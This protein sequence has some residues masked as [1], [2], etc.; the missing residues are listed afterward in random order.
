MGQDI[1]PDI[2]QL[3]I[4]EKI[5]R[6][7]KGQELH[8]YTVELQKGQVLKI[9]FVEKGTDVIAV[10][11]RDADQ[12][13]VS[14][15]YNAGNGFMRESLI[16][17]AEEN[18]VHDIIVRAQQMTEE[19]VEAKY[20]ITA[21]LRDF[22]NSTDTQRIQAEKLIEEAN[23]IIVNKDTENLPQ[24][25]SKL[26]ESIK[27][28]RLIG[29][30][31]WEAIAAMFL[32]SAYAGMQNFTQ[33]ETAYLK[34]LSLFDRINNKGELESVYFSLAA[35]YASSKNEAKA[36]L[37]I[38]QGTEIAR[39]L[40]DKRFE[41]FNSTL[42]NADLADLKE[43]SA[44]ITF[45]DIEKE[46]ATARVK[47]DKLAE[48]SVW[49]KKLYQLVIE[50][51]DSDDASN[52]H[53]LLNK[54]EREGLSLARE[55]KDRNA[56]MRI[57]INLGLGYQNIT[58]DDDENQIK[59][60]V[61]NEKSKKFL[62]QSL[63]I[64]RNTKDV[65]FEAVIEAVFYSL[66]ETDN[67]K[68]S[69]FFGKKSI[70][71]TQ[72]F[73]R[74]A[75]AADKE[76]QQEL[77]KQTEGI[78]EEFAT[79]LIS[80]EHR[81][82]EAL[83]VINLGRDQEFFDF[84]LI[85]NQKPFNLTFT[86]REA[87]NLRLFD[88]TLDKVAAKYSAP[89]ANYQTAA[90]E[91]RP[92][93]NQL[94]RNFDAEDSDKDL[95]QNV[96]DL[97]DMQNVLSELS[98][99]TG[100]N[101]AAIYVTSEAD[102]ILLITASQIKAFAKKD[103]IS[104]NADETSLLYQEIISQVKAGNISK[105]EAE[106]KIAEVPSLSKRKFDELLKEKP[107][108]KPLE[109]L[110]TLTSPQYDPRPA[111]STL[112]KRIFK[113]SEIKQDGNPG[114]TLENELAVTNTEVLLWSLRGALRYV[115]MAALY[116]EDNK[117]YLVEKFENVMFTRARKERFLAEP[118]IWT[119]GEGFGTSI[120]YTVGDLNFP[121]L[122]DVPQE[123]STILGDAA[124]NQKG[125]YNGQIFLNKSFTRQSLLN[126]PQNKPSFVHIASH[127]RFKAGDARNS[128]LLLGDGNTFSILDM[129]LDNNLFAGVDL[130]TLSACETAA[131]QEDANGKEIDGFAELAQRLGASSVIATLWQVNDKGTSAL[132]TEFYRLRKENPTASKSQIL[133]MAQLSLLYGKN[134]A[135]LSK[136]NGSVRG[137]GNSGKNKIPQSENTEKLIPFKASG[138]SDFEHPYFW[139]P[140]VLFGNSN[141]EKVSNPYIAA[142]PA[143]NNYSNSNSNS[144]GAFSMSNL[145]GLWEGVFD[146]QQYYC[147][148]EIQSIEG[149]T[150]RGLLH[151]QGAT[152]EVSGFIDPAS[153]Q[154]SFIETK[155]V[156]LGNNKDWLLGSNRGTFSV[157]GNNIS[158]DGF[159]GSVSY[160]WSFR[161]SGTGGSADSFNSTPN[162]PSS[163][164]SIKEIETS[165]K[166]NLFDETIR[167]SRIFLQTSPND[168]DANAYLGYSLLVKK[169]V[170][171][172][173]PYLENAI[174]SG[175]PIPFNLKRLRIPLIGHALENV[176]VV[177]TATDVLVNSG[178]STFQ[179]KFSDLAESRIENYNNQCQIV[180][181]K[182]MFTE[183]SA[184]SEK[185]KQD[186]K[187]FNLFPPGTILQPTLQGKIVVNY[188]ACNSQE[189]YLT[190]AMMTLISRLGARRN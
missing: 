159:A 64:A 10:A 44:S 150:F 172:A 111:A 84:K 93:L 104:E 9:D 11:G 38:G 166:S 188:A 121:D 62:L 148:L 182:G 139:A 39:S 91:L 164:V 171:N 100:K 87:E 41:T 75:K 160:K 60:K 37:Y 162:S 127:F 138:N 155:V 117:Q 63:L 7:I 18:G 17:V 61:N 169:D 110:A 69:I 128:F 109:L 59:E 156:S 107:D 26:Q 1:K 183:T 184:K 40:G 2:R 96:P 28:W 85:E 20:E 80:E 112:Y 72:N 131:Q 34:S 92:L 122:P 124:T 42:S 134:S 165:F 174:V 180:H 189:D 27:I 137:A 135:K 153:K 21:T 51:D 190:T 79:E 185:T 45:S 6:T 49:K 66:Y 163:S 3:A 101:H 167:L 29:D 58:E 177:I 175:Q 173:L 73:R 143:V 16:F 113:S 141:G 88:E 178:N 98:K 57:L 56:E 116:D 22:P 102:E 13:K 53:P 54:A 70:N 126:I 86:P 120:A 36:K 74:I 19:G 81:F 4:G 170:D 97:T 123:I 181:I 12:Q 83:Q 154:I 95:V 145:V 25:V 119:T 99:K 161:K 67:S 71:T 89:A 14:A 179:G 8:L 68:L 46:L 65:P 125:F 158:G 94:E 152:I 78:Y 149:N 43:G 115:P 55:M 144:S 48:L 129:Q 187:E 114:N 132:M 147:S 82:A 47:K 23:L 76:T 35:V 157:E 105:A 52:W 151:P 136:V 24:A 176:S 103:V 108:D 142:K 118:Q 30:K 32:G 140:F 168:K 33:S 106:Q 146:V 90:A 186:K 5:L 15:G 50:D 130:L 77:A 133:R 31:Y